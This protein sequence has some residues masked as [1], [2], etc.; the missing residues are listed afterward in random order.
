MK[1]IILA[2]GSGSR[3][4]PLSNDDTPKQLLKLD[5]KYSLLQNTF[6]RLQ[7]SVPAKDILTVTNAGFAGKTAAQLR[8]IA[9][10]FR[11][12]SE[13][14]AR[15][16]APAICC[17]LEYFRRQCSDDIVTIL[18]ADHLIEK[19]DEFCRSMALAEKLAAKD[20]IVTLGIKPRYPETGFGYIKTA[21]VL[22]P[23][24][25][26]EKFVEKP[27]LPVVQEYVASGEYFWNG[28]IFTGKISVFLQEFARFAPEIAALAARCSF[29][30]DKIDENIF[31][32]MPKISIDYAVMEKSSR[33]ALVELLSDWSD[34]GSW[35]AIYDLKEKDANG[36][37]VIGKALLHNV[38][39]SLIYSPESVFAVSDAENRVFVNAGSI[40][41]SCALTESQNVK[42]LSEN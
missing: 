14:C 21:E 23:G 27:S 19:T 8:E 31:S 24:F 42:F 15:N 33:I 2:G 22:E 34:L 17:A 11:I 13:P 16:T 4:W 12:L 40:S 10:D 41:M 28:G 29:A 9:P 39:N 37:V 36:N 32:G 38:R 18:P 3:L 26:V 1:A 25:K 5:S 30:D 6:L 35:Q 20:M 7:K